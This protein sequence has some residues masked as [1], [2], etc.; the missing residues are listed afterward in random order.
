[1]SLALRDKFMMR[2]YFP[3]MPHYLME[4]LKKVNH[5]QDKMECRRNEIVSRCLALATEHYKKVKLTKFFSV[6]KVTF[7]LFIF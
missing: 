3:F 7:Y 1:M 5:S 2:I 6:L 4:L